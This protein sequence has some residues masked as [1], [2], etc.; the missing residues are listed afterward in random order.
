MPFEELDPSRNLVGL[1]W[2]SQALAPLDAI[3][4]SR[5]DREVDG[6]REERGREGKERDRVHVP[7]VPSRASL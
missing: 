2:R 6:K 1:Q 4:T 3:L 5:S 7:Q